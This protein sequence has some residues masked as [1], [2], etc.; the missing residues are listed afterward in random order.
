MIKIMEDK[1]NGKCNEKIGKLVHGIDDR[2]N[3]YDGMCQ[4]FKRGTGE[5]PQMR[6]RL[7]GE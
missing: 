6:S 4:C 1:R 5:V 2:S 3:F 7:H